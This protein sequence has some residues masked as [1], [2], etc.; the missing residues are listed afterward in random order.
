MKRIKHSRLIGLVLITLV[1]IMYSNLTF[2]QRDMTA[3]VVRRPAKEITTIRPFNTDLLIIKNPI[4]FRPFVMND[5]G[6]NATQNSTFTLANGRSITAS[7]YLDALN[8]CEQR[9]NS[10]GYSLRTLGQDLTNSFRT[11][12]SGLLVNQQ[13]QIDMIDSHIRNTGS[14]SNLRLRNFIPHEEANRMSDYNLQ[15]ENQFLSI[16]KS[17]QTTSACTPT[18]N[19]DSS[20]VKGPLGDANLFGTEINGSLKITGTLI[21]KSIEA[22]YRV[23]ADV[24]GEHIDLASIVST[25]NIDTTGWANARFDCTTLGEINSVSKTTLYPI[26]DYC[27]SN[28]ETGITVPFD[29]YGITINLT[30]R[31]IGGSEIVYSII[32]GKTTIEIIYV[33]IFE[34]TVEL[35][36][37]VDAVIIAVE[38]KG[39][40]TIIDDKIPTQIKVFNSSGNTTPFSGN[41]YVNAEYDVYNNMTA[42]SGTLGAWVII[43]YPCW[44]WP[45]YCD[46]KIGGNIVDWPGIVE[47]HTVLQGTSISDCGKPWALDPN[48][49]RHNG[50][51]Q[52]YDG[53]HNAVKK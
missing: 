23:Q 9:L 15:V 37:S 27:T 30:A 38:T 46:K 29:L 3:R 24:F 48:D 10:K 35:S 40:F 2:A 44:S 32:P 25:L 39:T 28:L 20:W 16:L 26:S 4:V 47:A 12:N 19:I 42:L 51:P 50:P 13:R 45:P 1:E 53:N 31:I 8:L 52:T 17:S 11:M 14:P 34:G 7:Q 18:I 33:P 6:A 41:S 22:D 5:L 21:S 49:F 36:A 43:R